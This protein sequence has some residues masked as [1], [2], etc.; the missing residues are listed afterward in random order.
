MEKSNVEKDGEEWEKGLLFQE[1][2]IASIATGL[3]IVVGKALFE[4]RFTPL[5]DGGAIISACG[6]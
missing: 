5:N 6:C 3:P 1:T 2:F 4:V